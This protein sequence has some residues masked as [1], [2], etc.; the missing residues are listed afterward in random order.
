MSSYRDRSGDTTGGWAITGALAGVMGAAA[1]VGEL[2][3]TGRLLLT[4]IVLAGIIL[5][6]IA[7]F[8]TVIRLRRKG[9]SPI[10]IF[11]HTERDEREYY[12]RFAESIRRAKT[13]IYY[14]GRG[15]SN[16]TPQSVRN[17]NLIIGATREALANGIRYNRIQASRQVSQR[18]ADEYAKLVDE[19]PKQARVYGD[20]SDPTFVNIH[21]ADPDDE[22]TCV[23]HLMFEIERASGDGRHYRAVGGMFLYG[24]TAV[25][26]GIE[27]LFVA[28]I[29]KLPQLSSW[30]IR[31][32]N[33]PDSGGDSN[34]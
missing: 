20:T 14:T 5:L 30:E 22:E 21:V 19:F 34:R 13:E 28:R 6:G 26:R 8:A 23:V 33:I 7:L 12:Q 17:F 27:E 24:D 32:L 29:Q 4:I 31:A 3:L 15:F 1:G 9:P 16:K 2:L 18:W 10:F 25:A 11:I